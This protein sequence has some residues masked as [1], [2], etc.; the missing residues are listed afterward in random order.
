MSETGPKH[1][2]LLPIDRNWAIAAMVASGMVL[3]S[4]LG[5]GLTAANSSFAKAYWVSL[6]PI[7]GVLC[8][9]VSWFRAGAGKAIDYNLIGRQLLHWLAVG[10]ALLLE[11][12][13]RG[14][15]QETD[16]A[17]A[18]NSLLVLSLGCFL[19]GVHLERVFLPVGVLLGILLA[20]VD[21]AAEYQWLIFV[22]GGAT[23]AA[24][25][26]VQRHFNQPHTG[27]SAS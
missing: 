26:F 18:L 13:I 25:F 21:K 17:A 22:V 6:V 10:V 19:A 23:I 15:G 2:A 27:R 8:I 12:Y 7:F 9:S 14:S 24:I 4:L 3:L 11:F 20:L 1:K 16:N 5:V